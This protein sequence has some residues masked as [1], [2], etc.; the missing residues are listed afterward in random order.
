MAAL[1]DILYDIRNIADLMRSEPFEYTEPKRLMTQDQRLSR[2]EER[3]SENI[4]DI[5]LEALYDKARKVIDK[6]GR[7][8]FSIREA[9][10]LPFILNKSDADVLFVRT[11]VQRYLKLDRVFVFRRLLHVYFNSYEGTSS[12]TQYLKKELSQTLRTHPEF[13]RRI[14]YLQK[15]KNLLYRDE[16]VMASGFFGA[17]SISGYLKDIEFPE[18]L[19]GSR[20]VIQAILRA[21]R[22]PDVNVTALMELL[23]NDE[24]L[25]D[26]LNLFPFIA[27]SLILA[28]DHS[29]NQQYREALVKCLFRYM[30]DPRYENQNQWKRVNL[31]ARKI[32][33]SWLRR[34]DFEIFFGLIERTAG[35]TYTGDRMWRYRRAFWEAYLDD[36]YFTR[37]ILGPAALRLARAELHKEALNYAIL[38]GTQD[39]TQSLLM[40]TIGG[41]TFIE[42]SHN[43]KLRMFKYGKEPIPFME[44]DQLFGRREYAYQRVVRGSQPVFEVVHAGSENYTWQTKVSNWI[45]EH[46]GIYHTRSQWRVK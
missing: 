28:V 22:R 41:Y 21:F 19:Y 35:S 2:V 27:E 5:D 7:E 17:H 39:G 32:F 15:E 30:K 18:S 36:M 42:V 25:L 26:K 20:F 12:K 11:V 8:T 16:T 9:R 38:T 33:L 23:Q 14:P 44:S 1:K 4:Q 37:V 29:Q 34:N 24:K 13:L 45:G 6:R 43:G 40:F 10:N 46:C 3:M 31:K